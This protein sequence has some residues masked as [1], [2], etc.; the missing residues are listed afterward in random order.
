MKKKAKKNIPPSSE[1]A[2]DPT[3]SRT[4]PEIFIGLVAP[5][6]IDLSIVCEELDAA[7]REVNYRLHVIKL[8]G[9][10]RTIDKFKELPSAPEETRI[11]RHM[12][13]G[14]QL[15]RALRNDVMALLAAGAVKAFR[16]EK[17]GTAHDYALRQAYVF[18]S[19][20]HPHE[21]ETLRGLYGDAFFVISVYAPREQRVRELAAKIAASHHSSDVDRFRS[22]AERLLAIDEEE[23]LSYGQNVSSLSESRFVPGLPVPGSVQGSIGDSWN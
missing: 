21:I 8:S 18:S 12:L 10:L 20:K 1:S 9:L 2:F 13:A 14:T 16:R 6:G 19:L 5:V 4:D 7:F 17:Y 3:P 11:R 23:G 22:A 15:R